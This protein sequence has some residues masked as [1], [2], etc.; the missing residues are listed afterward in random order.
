[1]LLL[2]EL[3]VGIP[4]GVPIEMHTCTYCKPFQ[5]ATSALPLPLLLISSSEDSSKEGSHMAFYVTL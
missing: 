5:G 4:M 3:N 2:V 1:M